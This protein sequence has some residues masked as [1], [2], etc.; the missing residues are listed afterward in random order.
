MPRSPSI[1][2]G[3]DI[4]TV[5]GASTSFSGT[6]RFDSSLMIRGKFDGDIDA[7]GELYIDE[8]AVINAGR[9]RAMSIVVAGSVRGDLEAVDRVEFRSSAQVRGNVK[10]AKLRISD[11]VLFE[12]RCEM[13]RDEASFDP[14]ASKKE[15]AS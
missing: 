8:G 3:A 2:N 13:V 1:K 15:S 12:G 4:T 11:G 14:F 7:K 10:T 6:L 9:I 5:L